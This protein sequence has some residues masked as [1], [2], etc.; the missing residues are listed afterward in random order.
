M[1]AVKCDN[2]TSDT[3]LKDNATTHDHDRDQ[4]KVACSC[5]Q[6]AKQLLTILSSVEGLH[7]AG[8]RLCLTLHVARTYSSLCPSSTLTL[9][10]CLGMGLGLGR[11][12]DRF[13]IAARLYKA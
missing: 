8:H 5:T 4:V 10:L 9:S 12:V 3:P 2:S 6:P 1:R 11:G 7:S 13:L